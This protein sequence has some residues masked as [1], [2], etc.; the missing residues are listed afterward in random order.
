ARA[1]QMRASP[2]RPCGPSVEVTQ[3]GRVGVGGKLRAMRIVRLVM[4]LGL[5]ACSCAMAWARVTRVEVVSRA[6][7][8]GGQEF[9]AAGAYE[10]I[11][12]RVYVSLPVA[13]LHNRGIVDLANAVNL[14]DG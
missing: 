5:V 4:W 9:G 10:R 14:K 11:V 8:L 13:N 6:D 12:G 3:C 7:V 2:L 1:E